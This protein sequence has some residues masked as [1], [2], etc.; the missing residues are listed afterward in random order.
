[1][2]CVVVAIRLAGVILCLGVELWWIQD[3]SISGFAS[4][5]SVHPCVLEVCRILVSICSCLLLS[6]CGV[7]MRVSATVRCLVS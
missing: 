1:M 4:T 2:F 3:L 6:S 7:V 5:G